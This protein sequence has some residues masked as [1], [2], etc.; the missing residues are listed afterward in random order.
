MTNELEMVVP[1]PRTVDPD[2]GREL[3]RETFKAMSNSWVWLAGWFECVKRKE[4][5]SQWGFNSFT[6]YLRSDMSGLAE[7]TVNNMMRGLRY[8]EATEPGVV[9]AAMNGGASMSRHRSLPGDNALDRLSS[10][11]LKAE[12]GVVEQDGV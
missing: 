11:K 12:K 1:D 4:Y 10:L 3:A 9:E 6:D 8:L 5:W 2:Q 7:S